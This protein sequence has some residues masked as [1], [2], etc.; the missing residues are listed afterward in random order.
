MSFKPIKTMVIVLAVILVAYLGLDLFLGSVVKAG[1]N[2]FAPKITKTRVEL[3][4]ARISPVTGS[5]TLTGLFVGNPPGWR[6]DKA[7]SFGKIHVVVAPFSIFG[8]HVVVKD[9][10]IDQPE[11]VYET[12][13][14]SSN[15][16]G[17]LK[18]VSGSS[19]DDPSAQVTT[20]TGKPIKFEVKHFLLKNGHVKLGIGAAAMTLPMPPIELTDLGTNEGG[21]TSGQ[22]AVAVMRS[23]ATGVVSATTQ[24]AGKIGSTMGA[25]AGN[26]AERAGE[27][28][29][30]LF[31]EKK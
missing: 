9:I 24:A 26:A 2:R 12:R 27:G 18:N 1:V 19:T 4:G 17:L 31:G 16:G 10:V 8:D 29:K 13:F 3:A 6:S 23:V 28:L 14:V 7:F 15:I 25:A 11:F 22:L 20:K 30:S 21:I 5:G